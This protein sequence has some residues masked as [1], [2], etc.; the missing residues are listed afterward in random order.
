L[1]A[2]LALVR[3]DAFFLERFAALAAV[4][5]ARDVLLRSSSSAPAELLR[6]ERVLRLDPR[7]DDFRVPVLRVLVRFALARF[8]PVLFAVDRRA[9]VTSGAR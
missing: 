3:D 7:L 6:R 1:L 2:R 9:I 4:P 5:R 8:A